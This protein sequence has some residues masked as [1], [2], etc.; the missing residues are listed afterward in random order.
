[1]APREV[2]L[3][4]RRCLY[5]DYEQTFLRAR[6]AI[7]AGDAQAL[8]EL[9]GASEERQVRDAMAALLA[10]SDARRGCPKRTLAQLCRALGDFC[11]RD[12]ATEARPCRLGRHVAATGP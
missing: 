10:M 9:N 8:L 1:L 6:E 5:L 7:L 2:T 11:L 12:E 4:T 3:L